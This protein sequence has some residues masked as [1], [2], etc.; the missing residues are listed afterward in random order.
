MDVDAVVGGHLGE[1]RGETCR[2]AVL[3]RLD[4]AALDEL[5]RH[6]DQLLARERVADLDGWALLSRAFTELLA[7]QHRCA[8]DP[9][10]ARGRAVE[11]DMRAG[12]RRLRGREALGREQ[13]DAHRIDEA[14]AA[15]ALVEDGLA[16]DVRHADA[17]AVVTDTAHRARE[18]S[19]G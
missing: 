17:V 16:A 2:A 3:Q 5:E 10:A 4:E 18:V 14:V 9:V 1:R 6:L 7:R 8:A 19:V 12:S 11:N 13:A 15:V